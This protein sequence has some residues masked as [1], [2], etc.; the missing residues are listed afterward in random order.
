VNAPR[1]WRLAS[2]AVN[3]QNVGKREDNKWAKAA[4]KQIVARPGH[5]FVQADSTSIEAVMVGW[6]INDPKFM[7]MAAKSIHAWLA[8][9]S[10][11]W[12]FNDETMNLIKS[13]HK[14]LYARMKTAIYL[15]LF[16]GDSYLM[17][18]EDTAN[19]PTRNAAEVV[20]QKIFAMIPNLKPWQDSTREQAKREGFLSTAWGY[21]NY[22]Y[23][24]YTYKRDKQDRIMRDSY[25]EPQIKLGKDASKAIG[26]RPQNM[27]GAFM[28]DTVLLIGASKW[29][30]FMPAN[31]VVH[32][33]YTLEVPTALAEE[34]ANFLIETLTRPIAELGG[35][36][37]GCEVEI[38]P[39]GGNWADYDNETNPAGLRLYRKVEM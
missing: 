39:E 11:G 22:F 33:G 20:R 15:M 36:R 3:L 27:A 6:L 12:E 4:R 18:M 32:D 14:G 26:F 23:D 34:A 38:G 10:L 29:R 25:G 21:R 2:R 7:K 35:L 30:Q 19:F 24:V 5:C 13:E 37:I 8:A 9:E 28:R 16:G 17:H 31:I 1:T